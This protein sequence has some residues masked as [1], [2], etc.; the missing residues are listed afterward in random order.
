MPGQSA[1]KPLLISRSKEILDK[2]TKDLIVSK[3]LFPKAAFSDQAKKVSIESKSDYPTF[4]QVTQAGFDKALPDKEIK[5]Q[6]E[7]QREYRDLKGNVLT[8]TELGSE[9]EVHVK[10]RSVG[11]GT[12]YNVAI[13]DLLPGGF[14]V[15]LAKSR[16]VAEPVQP[17]EIAM[18]EGMHE[19]EEGEGEGEGEVGESAAE[20]HESESHWDS[21]H[22]HGQVNV[23]P[24]VR[25]HSRGPGRALRQRRRFGP[26]V[27]VPHQSDEQ[28]QVY[29]PSGLCRVHV[30][31]ER[32]GADVAGDNDR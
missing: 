12:Y 22:R 26:G 5:K 32:A 21:P 8:K 3:G 13:V 7:I 20:E 31:P 14:E 15:V 6:L 10:M 19:R 9:I 24:R 1:K 18:R 2:G 23:V 25:R 29:H 30:R 27:R 16:R 4:Y 28:G 11:S 17:R